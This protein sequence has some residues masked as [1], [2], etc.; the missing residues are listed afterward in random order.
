VGALDALERG[1][2]VEVDDA[3]L[4]TYLQALTDPRPIAR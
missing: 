3:A 1:D 2:F 4:E